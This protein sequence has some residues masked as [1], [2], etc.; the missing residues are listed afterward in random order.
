MEESKYSSSQS[1]WEIRK[2]KHQKYAKWLWVATIC[3]VLGVVG[4]FIYLSYQDLPSFYELENPK[5]N[6]AS[7]VF[8]NNGEVLGRYFVENRVNVEYDDLSPYLVQALVATEDERYYKHSGIDAE[9]LGRVLF[10]TILL[11][12]RSSGGAST[13]TQQT[14]KLLFTKKPGSGLERVFQKLKEWIIA[15]RLERKYTKEEIIAMY[16]NKF[17]FINGAYGIKAAAEIY[18]GKTQDSLDILESATLV[19]MLKNPS[20]YN[21]L[22]R[23]NKTEKRRNVVLKQMQKNNLLTQAEYDSLRQVPLDMSHFKR[24]THADGLA[25]Y[26]RMELRKELFKILARD[27]TRKSDGS[28]YDIFR[29]GLKIYTTIDPVIQ[30]LAEEAMVEHMSQLQKTFDKRWK[31]LDPWTY[32]DKET[33]DAEMQARKATMKKLIANSDRYQHNRALILN[34]ILQ[35]IKKDIGGNTL[36][37]SDIERMLEEKK[38]KGVIKKLVANKQIGSKLASNYKRVMKSEHW[39]ELKN[40]WNRFKNSTKKQFDTPTKMHVFAYNDKMEKDTIMT[41]L[42]SIKYHHQF[43]QIGSLAVD[44][45]DGHV[46][47]WVGGIN[48]KYFQFDHVRLSRQVGSTFKPFVYATA[49]AQQGISPCYEVDDIP[50]TIHKGEG[51]FGLLEDWTPKN[52]NGK[53]SG[54]RFTLKRGLQYSKNTVSVFLMKQLGDAEPVRDLVSR[55]GIPKSRVPRQPSI[56]LGATDLSVFEMAG[57]YTSFA[58]NGIYNRPI[59]IERIVDNNGRVIYQ[60]EPEENKALHPNP[61]YV[62][63]QMLKSTVSQLGGRKGF[64]GLKSEIGGKTG[65]TNDYVDGWF[66]GI[67]P[68]LV[69]G[70]WVGGEDRWIRF[71]SLRY[72][73]GAVMARPFFAKLLQKLEHTPDVDYDKNARFFRPPGDLGI[74]IDCDE[75]KSA[76]RNEDESDNPFT[77]EMFGDEDPFAEPDTTTIEEDPFQ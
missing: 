16:L 75:Y 57:A 35:K 32:R 49:I 17:P 55:M 72:G 77:E 28:K 47:A 58:N 71:R 73:I 2:P 20:L 34:D 61:N 9:A 24:K 59:F 60:E 29:D 26:F 27:D 54:E 13:I 44:P 46:K 66:M 42:D 8:A 1:V 30:K 14:A 36:R 40:K 23:L 43:L 69:V 21:P 52:A 31:N 56:C 12:D 65:T 76:P 67:T 10:K 4:L 38:N 11:Q 41:P 51:N 22:R 6:L 33:T 68:D 5:N 64:G 50:Y 48:H 15:L 37:D 62:M 74:V 3:A 39:T 45:I 25:P 7:P 70:T 63:V 19:G 53:Y 18:F